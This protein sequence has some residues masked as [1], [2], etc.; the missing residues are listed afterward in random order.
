M[1]NS[2]TFARAPFLAVE[3]RHAAFLICH[4]GKTVG[5]TDPKGEAMQEAR[6]GM[7]K[8]EARSMLERHTL[9]PKTPSEPALGSWTSAENAACTRI[10]FII[11]PACV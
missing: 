5:E 10:D 11:R 4:E 2:A 3:E 7:S 6:A 8:F 9:L 1:Q